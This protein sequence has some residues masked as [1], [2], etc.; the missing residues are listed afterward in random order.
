MVLSRSLINEQE[1][2]ATVQASKTESCTEASAQLNFLSLNPCTHT[3][4]C[5][6]KKKYK[7]IWYYAKETNITIWK[8]TDMGQLSPIAKN[9]LDKTK[10]TIGSLGY[11]TQQ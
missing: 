7:H 1:L 10:I 2:V 6:L 3:Q 5:I 9:T 4:F 8:L 11:F